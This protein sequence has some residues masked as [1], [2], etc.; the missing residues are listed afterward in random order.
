MY[1][2]E[3]L[4]KQQNWNDYKGADVVLNSTT[5][6]WAEPE[7]EMDLSEIKGAIW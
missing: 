1:T 6:M 3:L 2:A 7:K 5:A 4:K